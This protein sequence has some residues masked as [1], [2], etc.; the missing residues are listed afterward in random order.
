MDE[1][2][3]FPFSDT[4]EK[5]ALNPTALALHFYVRCRGSRLDPARFY[6]A[7][8]FVSTSSRSRG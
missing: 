6:Q 1:D 5:A 3:G 2:S 7:V 8:T 4:A